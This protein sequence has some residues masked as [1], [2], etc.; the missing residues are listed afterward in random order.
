M[1]TLGQ[2]AQI[3]RLIESKKVPTEQLQKLLESGLLS[4]LFEA[5][6]EAIDRTAFRKLCGLNPDSISICVEIGASDSASALLSRGNYDYVNPDL[7]ERLR[8]LERKP[9]EVCIT[10]FRLHRD[11]ISTG[12]VKAEM[13]KRGYRP[14]T[15]LELLAMGAQQKVGG[16][17]LGHCASLDSENQVYPCIFNYP[18][19]KR[20]GLFPG[21]NGWSKNMTFL[22][23]ELDRKERHEHE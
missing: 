8:C 3:L 10:L 22:A 14:A 5:N 1:A 18:T 23:V 4:D 17:F 15:L 16:D 9:G 21:E 19:E 7:Y 2:G 20:L 6:L 13:R 12:A 11:G